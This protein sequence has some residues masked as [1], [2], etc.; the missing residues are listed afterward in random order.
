MA[1]TGLLEQNPFHHSPETS[2]LGRAVPE[3]ITTSHLIVAQ[4][5]PFSP[6]LGRMLTHHR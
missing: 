5:P 6:A 1:T 4:P 2:Y 3:R